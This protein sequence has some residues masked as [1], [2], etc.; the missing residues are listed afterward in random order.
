MKAFK[1]ALQKKHFKCLAISDLGT[2]C[3][4]ADVERFVPNIL[5]A[6]WF[7]SHLTRPF[8]LKEDADRTTWASHMARLAV[9]FKVKEIDPPTMDEAERFNMMLC[10]AK[11]AYDHF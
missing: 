7:I 4:K 2:K 8:T 5:D 9:S 10:F 1:P 3:R 6:L 11:L